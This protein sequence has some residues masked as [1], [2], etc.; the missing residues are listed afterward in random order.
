MIFAIVILV[1]VEERVVPGHCCHHW[2]LFPSVGWLDDSKGMRPVE[3]CATY[4]Y[5]L[6]SRW[7]NKTEGLSFTWKIDV[8]MDSLLLH[9]VYSLNKT[10]SSAIA[11]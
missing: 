11:E 9:R 3:T 2:L 8:V 10:R 1:V 4:P 6:L 7:R 5:R